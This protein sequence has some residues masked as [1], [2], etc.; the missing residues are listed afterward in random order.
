MHGSVNIKF[1]KR[2][3]PFQLRLSVLSYIIGQ[4][5]DEIARRLTTIPANVIALQ[6]ET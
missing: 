4:K 3:F 1:T 5:A 6:E 2:T